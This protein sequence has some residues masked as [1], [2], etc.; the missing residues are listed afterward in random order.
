M[1]VPVSTTTDPFAAI[2]K[3]IFGNSGKTLEKMA[4]YV[5][6]ILQ[7]SGVVTFSHVSPS[8]AVG[9]IA[10]VLFGL[11]VSTPTPKSGPGQL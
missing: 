8:V 1:S 5:M 10:A 2:A 6:G 3:S 4:L 7:A 11:H 9:S